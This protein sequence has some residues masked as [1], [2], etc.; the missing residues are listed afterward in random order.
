MDALIERVAASM[1]AIGPP[2]KQRIVAAVSGGLDSMALLHVLSRLA[3]AREWTLTVAHYNHRLRGAESDADECFVRNAAGSL[4]LAF[5]SARAEAEELRDVRGKSMEMACRDARHRFL[6]DVARQTDAPS[7]ALAHHADDQL[8]LFVL[9][10]IRGAGQGLAGMGADDPSP[11]DAGLRLIRPF[12]HVPRAELAEFVA[13]AGIAFRE[14]SSN[15]S[16]G[17]E[18]NRVR[19]EALPFLNETFARNVVGALRKSQRIVSDDA[20]CV[21]D[22]ARRWLRA[23]RR[24]R[25]ESLHPAV[26]RQCLRLQLIGIGRDVGFDLIE[27]LRARPETWVSIARGEE[28]SRSNEGLIQE[29]R[30]SGASFSNE[31]LGVELRA[32]AGEFEF[33]GTAI[34]WKRRATRADA[35]APR[36]L[37]NREI[38][39]ADK[40]GRKLLL[41]H[42]RP[43]DRFQ[44]IGMKAPLKLQDWFVNQKVPRERRRKLLVAVAENG[45]IF[46]VE[47]LR[48]GERFKV[49]AATRR[50]LTWTWQRDAD[51]G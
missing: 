44:P 29:R 10:L 46:W 13:R 27:E 3:P 6:A 33:A 5:E 34:G 16:R 42:W 1:G 36:K 35:G 15:A 48:I 47:G 2:P 20:A 19:R 17:P 49:V 7:L 25:F 51:P 40:V 31:E 18:R 50:R 4:G 22:L 24:T 26:Q 38:F 9:R 8:E 14:D 12:L 30:S 45:D 21:E 23:R 39:D 28:V 11:A 32:S 41:R 37:P 43:G